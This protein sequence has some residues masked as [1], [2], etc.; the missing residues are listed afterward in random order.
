MSLRSDYAPGKYIPEIDG[1]R[2]LAVIAVMLFHLQPPG[3]SLGWLGVNL[4]FVI[5]SFLIIKILAVYCIA[6]LSWY[7]IEIWC[8]FLKKHLSHVTRV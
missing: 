6:I 4:F 3:F 2:A 7:S 8:N 5:S 1:L